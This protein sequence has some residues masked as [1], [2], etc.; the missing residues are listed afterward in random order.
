LRDFGVS[1]DWKCL[2][3]LTGKLVFRGTSKLLPQKY[4]MNTV[5]REDGRLHSGLLF[6]RRMILQSRL[7]K[8]SSCA[9]SRE[10]CNE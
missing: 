3:R 4:N 5:T 6:G 9:S 2:A 7:E 8:C 10:L 1:P